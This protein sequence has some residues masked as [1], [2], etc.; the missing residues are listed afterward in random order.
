V[1]FSDLDGTLL[2]K[3][4]YSLRE[5]EPALRHLRSEGIPLILC[6]SKTF[7]EVEWYRLCLHNTHPFVVETGGAIYIPKGY[8]PFSF[9]CDDVVGRYLVLRLGGT[10]QEMVQALE[11]LAECTGVALRG[12][13]DMSAEEIAEI[14]SL[15]LEEASRAKRREHDEPFLILEPAKARLVEQSSRIPVTHGGRFYHL[16]TSDKGAAVSTLIDMYKKMDEDILT[17]GVGDS[18]NDLPMLKCVD[19]PILVQGEDGTHDPEV[20][21]P[22]LRYA[23]AVG[24]AGL[25]RE[26]LSLLAQR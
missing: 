20:V 9:D 17:V 4:G 16:N 6:T 3:A 5:A 22:S 25:R 8:F 26:L 1:V 13:S 24:P 19:V 23:P 7:A 11:E 10:Y 18:V 21:L 12:F 2:E 14:S 15:T